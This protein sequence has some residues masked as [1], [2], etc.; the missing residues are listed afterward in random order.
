MKEHPW[1]KFRNRYSPPGSC[2]I[3]RHAVRDCSFTLIELLV[4]IAIIAILAAMLLPALN[5]SR[6][7]ART[8]KCAS[9]L[10]QIMLAVSFYRGDNGD[11][12]P[13][14]N[15]TGRSQD[16]DGRWW[17][18]LCAIYLPVKEWASEG[19]GSVRWNADC[20][21]SCPA[22]NENMQAEGTD[23]WGAGYAPY[24]LGPITWDTA[25]MGYGWGYNRGEKN[26]LRGSSSQVAN[27]IVLS[28]AMK[29]NSDGTIL[30]AAESRMRTHVDWLGNGAKQPANWHSG[31]CNV[32]FADG[33]VEYHLWSELYNSEKKYFAWW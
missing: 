17:T 29:R 31:G 8:A 24:T 16:T 18:N 12:Y 30:T 11:F 20:V 21:W 9:N 28:D 27:R 14:A 3:P 33:R 2:S 32:T 10:K 26:R 25:L 4:V 13:M 15:A 6:D 1:K 5:K 22:V 19:A 7:R 23:Y